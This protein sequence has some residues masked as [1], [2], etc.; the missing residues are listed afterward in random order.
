[1][2][3]RI[4]VSP[5]YYRKISKRPE[6]ISLVATV[7]LGLYLS[8]VFSGILGLIALAFSTWVVLPWAFYE[9]L[10][11]RCA[12]T[13]IETLRSA[14]ASLFASGIFFIIYLLAHLIGE[15]TTLPSTILGLLPLL[16]AVALGLGGLVFIGGMLDAFHVVN[17]YVRLTPKEETDT[18]TMISIPYQL[19]NIFLIFAEA[20][21][22]GPVI[23]DGHA[24]TTQWAIF[25]F[26]LI[27]FLG[28][29]VIAGWVRSLFEPG[30]PGG[31]RVPAN[32]KR[33]LVIISIMLPYIFLIFLSGYV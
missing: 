31:L 1:M 9:S 14:Q 7:I 24:N 3:M 28:A 15:T 27:T 5:Q 22:I 26:F 2:L 32:Q 21:L 33:T 10:S 4:S 29:F 8:D 13:Q 23:V 6:V 19:F 18:L 11:A 20:K 17:F 12:Q 16:K 30:Q 25:A